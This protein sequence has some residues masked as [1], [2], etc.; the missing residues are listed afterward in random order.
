MNYLTI[1]V[2]GNSIYEIWNKKYSSLLTNNN[3][4]F[5]KKTLISNW[6]FKFILIFN[7]LSKKNALLVQ[8]IYIID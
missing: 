3:Y 5:A 8:C 6:N 7:A 4:I 2:T 1:T